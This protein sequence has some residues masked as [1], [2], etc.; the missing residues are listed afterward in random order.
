MNKAITEGL[1][2]MPPKFRDGLNV[3]STGDGRPGS[4][5]FDG[6]APGSFVTAD[7]DFNGCLEVAKAVATLPVRHMGV[8]PIRPGCY[9]RVTARI[10]AITGALPSVRIAGTPLSGTTVLS[11]LPRS[12]PATT[13]TAHNKVMEVSAIIGTGQRQG[14]DMVWHGADGGHIGLDLTGATGG[15]VRIEDL[16]IEDVTNVFL[17]DMLGMVDVRDFGAIGDGVADDSAAFLAADAA[18]NG[19]EVLVSKGVYRL[20]QHVTLQ[21]PVRFEGRIEMPADKRLILMNDFRYKHYLDAFRNEEEAFRKAFQALLNFSDHESLDLDGRRISITKPID[22]QA[23]EGSKTRFEIRR[24]IRNGLLEAQDGPAW[25]PRVITA[26]ARYSKAAPL[27]LTNVANIANIEIGSHI[28]GTGVGREVYVRDRNIAAQTITLSQPLYGV[29]GTQSFTFT[30]FRYMLDFS[31]FEKL[32]QFQMTDIELQCYGRASGIMM[33]RD[34]FTFQLRDST[35]NR[36]ADRCLT[37]IG[38]A[39]QDLM[40]DRCHFRSN[41]M[42]L[43]VSARKTMVFNVNANDAKIRECRVVRFERFAVMAGTGHIFNGNHWFHGDDTQ[44]GVRKG[45]LVIANTNPQTMITSNYIDN[46][47]IEWTNEYEAYPENA[48][49]YSF[50]GLTIDGNNFVASNVS[51]WF[52]WIV[53]KPYGPGHHLHGLAVTSNVFRTF[54]GRVDRVDHVDAGIAGMDAGRHRNVTFSG[55]IYH[56]IDAETQNPMIFEHEQNAA[57]TNWDISSNGRL[58]FGGWVKWVSHVCAAGQL[59]YGNGQ[60]CFE[61]PA[62]AGY[63]GANKDR[64]QLSFSQPVRGAMR[65]ELRMDKPF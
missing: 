22:M 27:V 50:G 49:Q 57:Q 63:R 8:T 46:C 21:H 41:E 55:N 52:R 19:R 48:N 29:Q 5:T 47:S 6:S 45:G 20:A 25:A 56:G 10:K 28:A 18:A 4:D 37:S 26:T 1:V 39:C 11:G 35:I 2:F 62:C 12:G 38:R 44:N 42:S 60:N 61:A 16:H 30:R 54:N 15:V 3:W 32:S 65:G 9:L 13:L 53:I 58:P 14:V 7:S 24:I 23:A 40:L 33:A 43:P 59:R 64:A 17:R 36:P 34:G 51:N 31:G